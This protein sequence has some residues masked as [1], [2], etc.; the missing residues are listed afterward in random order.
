MERVVKHTGCHVAAASH[1]NHAQLAWN[2]A[3]M[4]K[5]AH[6]ITFVIPHFLAKHVKTGKIPFALNLLSLRLSRSIRH[7]LAQNTWML[8]NALEIVGS[9]HFP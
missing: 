8:S 7:Q 3:M 9:I 4:K 6:Q 5:M 2:L 1:L